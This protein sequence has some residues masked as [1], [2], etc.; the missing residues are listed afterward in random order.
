MKDK[1]FIIKITNDGKNDHVSYVN[2]GM[3]ALELIGLL[4]I[5]QKSLVGD[6]TIH[7]GDA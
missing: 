4:Q 2:H 7:P 1:E 5:I 3:S 6:I